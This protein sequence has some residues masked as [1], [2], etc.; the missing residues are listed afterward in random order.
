MNT[1]QRNIEL[2][3]QIYLQT[4]V[5]DQIDGSEFDCLVLDSFEKLIAEAETKTETENKG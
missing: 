3:K 2:L 1:R 4:M 5:E